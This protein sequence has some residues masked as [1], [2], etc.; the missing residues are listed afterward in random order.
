MHQDRYHQ[1][2]LAGQPE[3]IEVNQPCGSVHL[4]GKCRHMK[5]QKDQDRETA[6][7]AGRIQPVL[8]S[9]T[10]SYLPLNLPGIHRQFE[11]DQRM[12]NNQYK[13]CL[14]DHFMGGSSDPD[15]LKG[16]KN[17]VR[18]KKDHDQGGDHRVYFSHPVTVLLLCLSRHFPYRLPA[19]GRLHFLRPE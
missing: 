16:T 10:H 14:R 3:C 4:R 9:V 2:D 12:Y 18:H 6:D 19:A 8:L 1:Q 13:G 17:T 7:P 5:D 11:S 15:H